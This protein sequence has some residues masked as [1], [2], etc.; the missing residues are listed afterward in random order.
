MPLAV[1]LA[2]VISEKHAYSFS[3]EKLFGNRQGLHHT[4]IE[5]VFLDYETLC[6]KK[7]SKILILPS[8]CESWVNN[9]LLSVTRRFRPR[10]EV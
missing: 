2:F 6:R 1:L 9:P 7:N 8:N 4:G 5:T 10:N 3:A